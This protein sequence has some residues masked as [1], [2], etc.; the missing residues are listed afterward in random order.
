MQRI[1][2][3]VLLLA[4]A[5]LVYFGVSLWKANPVERA[6]D[7][8]T[9]EASNE[10][11]APSLPA[12]APLPTNEPV[13]AGVPVAATV[14]TDPIATG[15][16]EVSA[17][18]LKSQAEPYLAREGVTAL[19]L[20]A[21]FIVTGDQRFLKQALA[22]FPKDPAVLY[23]AL[24]DAPKGAERTALIERFKAADPNNPLP[25]VFSAGELFEDGRAADAVEELREAI[26]RPGFYTYFNERA[27]MLRELARNAGAGEYAA[28]TIALFRHPLPHLSAAMKV[29]RGLQVYVDAQIADGNHDSIG[30]NVNLLYDM[31]RMFQTPEAARLLVGQLVGVALERKALEVAGNLRENP[32]PIAPGPRSA[33]LAQV[34][35]E[36][37]ALSKS[38][39]RIHAEPALWKE[40]FARFRADGEIAALRWVQQQPEK[41]ATTGSP[42]LTIPTA[43]GLLRK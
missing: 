2:L 3:P 36:A 22:K 15:A 9:A 5:G 34:R 7:F 10:P 30:A 38:A 40:Y 14:E 24:Q 37:T 27:A 13:A 11:A 6:A 17:E 16:L 18:D 8:R 43:G 4:A 39:A 29:S 20:L 32:L 1:L 19:Q 35:E 41:P 21:G 28:E 42:R 26:K 25:W 31:G 12:F 33:E 23:Q